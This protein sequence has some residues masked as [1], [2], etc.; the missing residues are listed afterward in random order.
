MSEQPILSARLRDLHRWQKWI[1]ADRM[2]EQHGVVVL[3]QPADGGLTLGRGPM[4]VDLPGW[5]TVE[6]TIKCAESGLVEVPDPA[7]APVPM[8]LVVLFWLFVAAGFAAALWLGGVFMAAEG[9]YHHSQG[10]GVG[11]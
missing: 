11:R 2:K 4:T 1:I 9:A 7:S 5:A 3:G 6:D 8:I 10:M